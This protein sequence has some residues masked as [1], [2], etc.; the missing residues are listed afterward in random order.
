MVR[1]HDPDRAVRRCPHGRRRFHVARRADQFRLAAGAGRG[2]ACAARSA[3]PATGSALARKSDRLPT[4]EEPSFTHQLIRVSTIT[5]VGNHEIVRVRPFVRVAGNLSLAAPDLSANIPPFNPQKLLAEVRARRRHRS[6][7]PPE[8]QPDAE[9]A[10]VMR[11]LAPMLPK[12]KIALASPND[13]VL[14]RVRE[15]AEWSRK[16]GDHLRRRPA[17]PASSSPMPACR[18]PIL[19]PASKRASCP[20]TSRCCRRPPSRRPAAI[21]STRSVIVAKKGDSVA[22]ILHDLGALARRDRGD[23]ARAR[24][25]RQGRRHQAGP[26][27]ARAAVAGAQFQAPAAGARDRRRRHRDR[28]GGGAVRHRQIR[29][30]RRE[31]RRLRSGREH[32]RHQPGQRAAASRSIRASTKPRCATRCR[33]RSSKT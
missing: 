6:D 16:A 11:D 12:L 7:A 19:T 5:R 4:A 18:T 17:S 31:E 3:P 24:H 23:H 28:R 14:A 32:R 13:E 10:F 25:L 21:R 30:G 29:A 26:E 1:R 2:G 8:A 15:A 27:A 33:A 9:V 22:S 20:R